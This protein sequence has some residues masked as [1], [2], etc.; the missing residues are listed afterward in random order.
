MTTEGLLSL[1]YALQ[2]LETVGA[3]SAPAARLPRLRLFLTP[4][5][6]NRSRP[7]LTAFELHKKPI[8]TE[9]DWPSNQL[10]LFK[11]FGS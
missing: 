3:A 6:A 7:Q 5:P 4:R 1:C 10:R 2:K 8:Q 9:F 11:G